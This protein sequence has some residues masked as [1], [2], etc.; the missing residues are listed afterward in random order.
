MK[1]TVPLLYRHME[2][3]IMKKVF[4]IIL[5]MLLTLSLAA[6]GGIGGIGG[7][8]GGGSS[9]GK[10]SSTNIPNAEKDDPCDCCPECIQ[11]ECICEI[12]GRDNEYDCLCT[13]PD[14]GGAWTISFTD[15]TDSS[16]QVG[17]E[18]MFAQVITL[19]FEASSLNEGG[20]SGQFSGE[21]KMLGKQDSSGYES[22]AGGLITVASDWAGPIL[23]VSFEIIDSSSVAPAV[24]GNLESLKPENVNEKLIGY[25]KFSAAVD[26]TMGESWYQEHVLGSGLDLGTGSGFTLE[27]EMQ[28]L[29]YDAGTAMLYM[30]VPGLSESLVYR[31][32]IAR[33]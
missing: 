8:A 18:G 12:C 3:S 26:G 27:V 14:L 16:P 29:I 21:G 15:V 24:D 4:G 7:S 6:C 5:V 10:S 11:E 25:T 30:T 9:V 1:K 33:K 20:F 2:E 31:G 19:C 17:A 22:L 13:A 28:I 23:P 32:T